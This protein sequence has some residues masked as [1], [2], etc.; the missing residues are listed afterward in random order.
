MAKQHPDLEL[1]MTLEPSD[2]PDSLDAAWAR[3]TAA[4]PAGWRFSLSPVYPEGFEAMA[5]DL[6][7]ND[8]TAGSVQYREVAG[9]DTPVATLLALIEK[10]AARVELAP[11]LDLIDAVAVAM[12][13]DNWCGEHIGEPPVPCEHFRSNASELIEAL[14]AR[15][16][17]ITPIA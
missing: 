1:S 9:G 15:G 10:M 12:A 17:A 13:E 7:R 11:E 6:E 3:A 16:L 14:A 5:Y 8:F 4:M 2:D